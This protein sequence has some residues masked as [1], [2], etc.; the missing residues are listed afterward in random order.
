MF[1]LYVIAQVSPP[2]EL[3]EGVEQAKEEPQNTPDDPQM[4]NRGLCA[5]DAQPS[6]QSVQSP[7]SLSDPIPLGQSNP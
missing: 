6:N 4:E 1:R 7:E 5:P 3:H 2:S